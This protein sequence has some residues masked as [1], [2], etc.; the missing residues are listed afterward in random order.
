MDTSEHVRAL[1]RPVDGAGARRRPADA[2]HPPRRR[3]HAT[4]GTAARSAAA[5][6]AAAV[7]AVGGPAPA[8]TAGV[9]PRCGDVV[10]GHVVLQVDLDCDTPIG[11]DLAEGATLDLGGHTLRGHGGEAGVRTA[12][13]GGTVRNGTIAGWFDGVRA[14]FDGPSVIGSVRVVEVTVEDN[15]RGVLAAGPGSRATLERVTARGN[16]AGVSCGWAAICTVRDSHLT[17]NV[18][19]VDVGQAADATVVGSRLTGNDRGVLTTGERVTVL[20]STFSRNDSAVV[21]RRGVVEARANVFD[22]N[23]TAVDDAYSPWD[24]PEVETSRVVNNAFTSNTTAVRLTTGNL[25]VAY[26]AFRRNG[27]GILGTS[28][29]R[30]TSGP[31]TATGNALVQ[32]GDGIVTTAPGLRL[33]QNVASAG[34]GW[35]IHAPHAVDL[36]G[37]AVFG[38]ARSPQLVIGTA[39]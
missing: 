14:E 33:R 17:G 34:T 5:V 18:D 1:A 16:G 2:H 39:P 22:C 29:V 23:T 31:S 24:A 27:T 20:R 36:G 6:V 15:T 4:P 13:T 35:G 19:G 30:G 10:Q 9:A 21:Y 7:V 3:D 12:G 26:N 11:L 38:N 25:L 8:A 28:S 37:N 32:N